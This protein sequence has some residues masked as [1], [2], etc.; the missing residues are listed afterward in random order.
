MRHGQT[1]FLLYFLFALDVAG[2]MELDEG[3]NETITATGKKT[4][5]Y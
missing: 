3:R 4:K 1:E 2:Q 5:K